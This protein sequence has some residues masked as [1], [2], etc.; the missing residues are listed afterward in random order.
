MDKFVM[1]PRIWNRYRQS[2]AVGLKPCLRHQLLTF[3]TH[4][5]CCDSF[6]QLMVLE[7]T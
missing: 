6:L 4:A 5:A 1:G 3:G 2:F 7:Q